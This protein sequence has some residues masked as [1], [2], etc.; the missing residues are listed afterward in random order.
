MRGGSQ[1]M[2]DVQKKKGGGKRDGSES[3]SEGYR[4]TR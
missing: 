3:E 2:V 4:R 1:N